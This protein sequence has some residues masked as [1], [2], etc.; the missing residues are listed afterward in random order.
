MKLEA[1][2]VHIYRTNDGNF[3]ICKHR[4]S[5]QEAGCKGIYLHTVAHEF[6]EVCLGYQVGKF[7]IRRAGH[8]QLHLYAAVARRT[9]GTK[10]RL[11]DSEVG[12]GNAQG[13]L[14]AVNEVEK[15]ILGGIDR[16]IIGAIREG[17]TVPLP[18]Y[19]LLRTVVIVGLGELAAHA[20]PHTQK[21][22]GKAPCRLA[23]NTH[24]AIFPIAETVNDVGVFIGDIDTAGVGDVPVNAGDL[25]VVAVV[26][27]QAI[28]ILMD[29]VKDLCLHT[30][31]PQHAHLFTAKAH[32]AAE[33]VKDQ[34][35]LHALLPLAAEDVHKA[36]KDL[37]AGDDVILHEDKLLRLLQSGKHMLKIGLTCGQIF[38]IAA[39]VGSKSSS[40]GISRNAIP[41]GNVALQGR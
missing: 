14:G 34:L 21:L 40:D 9:K 30:H 27:V 28:H 39:A 8:H 7:V 26:E 35:D 20:L 16:V 10:H 3:V 23:G 1:A 19:R 25:T 6:T 4:F 29:R 17:L 11:I 36:I 38:P 41:F 15:D 5:V 12:R 2:V 31:T 32:H 22:T 37:T 18:F 33:I 24:A 13:M